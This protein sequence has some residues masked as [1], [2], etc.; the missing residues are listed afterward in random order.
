MRNNTLL[1]SDLHI[2]PRAWTSRPEIQGD[3]AYA[4][5]QIVQACL[6]H[7]VAE[8]V[9][10]GDIHDVAEPTAEDIETALAG[11]YQLASAGVRVLFIDGDHDNK[12]YVG[13]LPILSLARSLRSDGPQHLDRRRM[14]LACGASISGLDYRQPFLFERTLQELLADPTVGQTD[15][16]VC[17]QRWTEFMGSMISR[18]SLGILPHAHVWTGDLHQHRSL[19]LAGK[20]VLS[21]GATHMRKID[22]PTQHAVFL[23]DDQLRP[24]SYILRSRKVTHFQ[25]RDEPTLDVLIN[26]YLAAA[27]TPY[28]EAEAPGM[29]EPIRKPIVRVQHTPD[30]PRCDQRLEKAIAGRAHLITGLLPMEQTDQYEVAAA[31]VGAASNVHDAMLR[32]AQAIVPSETD[33]E[34]LL[35]LLQAYQQGGDPALDDF[36][37]RF[38]AA[39]SAPR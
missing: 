35:H 28:S 15:V 18:M 27:C 26:Q 16:F 11:C 38:I 34:L 32:V 17:H 33:R 2:S 14:N 19:P 10:A 13:R 24:S 20:M 8:L 25:V 7:Q 29:P 22:E 1:A 6:D 21:P 31:A 30:L 5:S 12:G 37:D 4:W 36:R 39:R 3:P 9:L 23:L